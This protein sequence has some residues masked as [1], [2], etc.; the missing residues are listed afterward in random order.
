MRDQSRE[1]D[2]GFKSGK[3]CT[4]A[5]VNALTKRQMPIG[6]TGNIESVRVVELIRVAIC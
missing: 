5:E 6:R 4:H 2:L 1:E 3:R